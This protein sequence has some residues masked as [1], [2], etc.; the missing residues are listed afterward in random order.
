MERKFTKQ[1]NELDWLF[2]E[3]PNACV[4]SGEAAFNEFEK[5]AENLFK[6]AHG[7]QGTF[8][9]ADVIDA[10]MKGASVAQQLIGYGVCQYLLINKNKQL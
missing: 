9:K 1:H 3:V 2:P 8:T 6:S 10:F 7:D 5:Y 4:S